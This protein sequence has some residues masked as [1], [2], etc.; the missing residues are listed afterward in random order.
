MSADT[1]TCRGC[2][3]GVGV[4]A[5]SNSK[6]S[7]SLGS[8]CNTGDESGVDRLAMRAPGVCVFV[9][10]SADTR[11]RVCGDWRVPPPLKAFRMAAWVSRHAA[12]CLL[13]IWLFW[14]KKA[15][16]CNMGARVME[17]AKRARVRRGVAISVCQFP[18]VV[19]AV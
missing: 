17:A 8:G 16:P 7:Q 10:A 6:S 5:V 13:M 18:G 4:V 12:L 9:P 19:L 1:S 11:R 3:C 14:A 15:L 2:R